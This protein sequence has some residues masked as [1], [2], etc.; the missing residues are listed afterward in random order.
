[1]SILGGK[2][3][4][5]R[6]QC[7]IY[8][9]E[10]FHDTDLAGEV[11]YC[12]DWWRTDFFF[13]LSIRELLGDKINE[14]RCRRLL[15]ILQVDLNW[16]INAVSDGQRRRC[17]LLECLATEKSVYIMDEITTD[18]DLYAREGLLNFLRYETEERGA[19]IFYATHIF[20]C[21]ADWA[22]HILFFKGG[23]AFKCCAMSELQEYQDLVKAKD[24]VPLYNL[25]KR[26]VFEEYTDRATPACGPQSVDCEHSQWVRDDQNARLLERRLRSGPEDLQTVGNTGPQCPHIDGPIIELKNMSYSPEK[27]TPH[28]EPRPQVILQ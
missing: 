4:I 8:G 22:T 12:G 25:M 18:L 11:M 7:Q 20:D 10:V 23:K 17:Q 26:W 14:A 5:P 9:K 6:G 27:T 1:L 13:N 15:D 2:N 28:L 3:M 19:T 24:R 16:R 21:L